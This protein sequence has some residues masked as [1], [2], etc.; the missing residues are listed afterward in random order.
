MIK[1]I[2]ANGHSLVRLGLRTALDQ[3]DDIVVI[4]EAMDGTEVLR[5]CEE[6][7]PDILCLD[8]NLP[9][10]N[11]EAVVRFIKEQCSSIK[12]ILLGDI[13]NEPEIRTMI[14]LGVAGCVLNDEPLD[15]I[16]RA[17]HAVM[18]GDRWLS[19]RVVEKLFEVPADSLT[20]CE[21]EQFT[22][23]ECAVL[24]LLLTGYSN[25]Q[26]AEELVIAVGTVK[27]HLINIYQK[28]GVH[29][30]AEVI[31]KI[32]KRGKNDD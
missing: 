7:S 32:L 9:G 13:I 8:L 2:L 3:E 14:G 1:V 20:V 15:A 29:S 30:R 27:N 6:H 4:G 31:S 24:D 11:P 23:R 26:I 10:Q 16:I 22:E 5:L 12:I 25:Q 19:Q 28:L 18:I 17:I 21:D